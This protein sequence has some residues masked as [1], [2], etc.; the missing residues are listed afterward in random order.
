MA[1]RICFAKLSKGACFFFFFYFKNFHYQA[2]FENRRHTNSEKQH[3]K[4]P[5]KASKL[6]RLKERNLLRNGILKKL[7]IVVILISQR[8]KR[9][10]NETIATRSSHVAHNRTTISFSTF[11]ERFF[12]IFRRKSTETVSKKS[13]RRFVHVDC[14]IKLMLLQLWGI[15]TFSIQTTRETI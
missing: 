11:N 2:S 5:I 7:T 9:K 6:K 3:G 8:K 14:S 15:R 1:R 12:G 4:V 13:R 10:M